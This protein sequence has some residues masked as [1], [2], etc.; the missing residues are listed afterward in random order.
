MLFSVE[1]TGVGIPAHEV[2]R[3][4]EKFHRAHEQ[5]GRSYEG[6]GI[7]LALTQELVKLHGGQMQVE[8]TFG[9]GTNF[10]VLIP[11]G[12]A[13]LPQEQL[14]VEQAPTETG[15]FGKS[16]VE[17]AGRWAPVVQEDSSSDQSTSSPA[18]VPL[19]RS[20]WLPPS[21]AGSTVLIVDD[22]EDVRRFVKGVLMQ[23]Y[24][25]VEAANG[26]DA[27][28]LIHNAQP[29]LIISDVMMPGSVNGFRL[30]KVLR[31]SSSIPF[32]FVSAEASE[33]ARLD[34]LQAGAD[35]YLAKP[36][37][38]DELMA[39]VHTLLDNGR[40]RK[41]LEKRVR[42]M[43]KDLL[44]SEARFRYSYLDYKSNLDCFATCLLRVF[45]N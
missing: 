25:V 3:I 15:I 21:T 24:S 8:S 32:I 31:A 17:E 43:S 38:P 4:F 39:R 45:S 23:C 28:T 26:R 22:N 16:I 37:S 1:D 9:Q 2:P 11:V 34:G 44:E 20:V 36:F 12:N 30:L 6:T 29:D 14:S 27:L 40:M 33:K 19:R 35:D 7:G 18:V 41:E 13:H 10:T 42:E 5:A